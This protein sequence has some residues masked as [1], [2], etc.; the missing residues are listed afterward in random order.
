MEVNRFRINYVPFVF[1]LSLLL[2]P[3]RSFASAIEITF[4]LHSRISSREK[5]ARAPIV[6]RID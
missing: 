2:R 3:S 1:V 5:N 4:L 6:S